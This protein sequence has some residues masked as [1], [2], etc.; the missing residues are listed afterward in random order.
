[1]FH[2]RLI[3]LDLSLDCPSKG[4][5]SYSKASVTTP[6]KWWRR[7]V[8][9]T[10][11]YQFLLSPFSTRA[12]LVFDAQEL[13]PSLLQTGVSPT[14]THFLMDSLSSRERV[15]S[16]IYVFIHKKTLL[17]AFCDAQNDM[18]YQYLHVSRM[19]ISIRWYILCSFW[20]KLCWHLGPE[21]VFMWLWMAGWE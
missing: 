21:G 5:Q 17:A 16:A 20:E 12:I 13:S 2:F 8:V 18:C 9:V 10:C 6:H 15:F 11:M 4:T 7:S 1:M 14:Y 3:K 19:D